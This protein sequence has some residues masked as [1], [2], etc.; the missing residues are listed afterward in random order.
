MFSKTRATQL[1][2]CLAL[3]LTLGV[4]PQALAGP[5]LGGDIGE[6]FADLWHRAVS[7]VGGHGDAF[8]SPAD[9]DVKP[10]DQSGVGPGVSPSSSASSGD[11]GG[12]RTVPPAGHDSPED[13]D[14]VEEYGP[15]IIPNG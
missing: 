12:L 7:W 14:P 4:A 6:L 3:V 2:L 10:L 9:L 13:E 15:Y 8:G 11:G 1:T 5:N